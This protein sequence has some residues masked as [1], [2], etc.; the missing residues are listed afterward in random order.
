[1]WTGNGASGAT[2]PGVDAVGDRVLER[3]AATPDVAT[4]HR[5]IAEA[6]GR[7]LELLVLEEALDQLGPGVDLL[8][9]GVFIRL[10][11]RLGL[12]VGQELARLQVAQGRRHHQV[13]AGDVDVE[14]LHGVE[15]LEVLL[16]DEGDRDVEDLELVLAHQV[17]EQVEGALEHI[18]RDLVVRHDQPRPAIVPSAA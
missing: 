3:R 8:E 17:Q 7:L 10:L 1:L 2:A 5:P 14:A 18:D 9:R 11:D 6:V 4:D 13:L 12:G 15:V 16:G